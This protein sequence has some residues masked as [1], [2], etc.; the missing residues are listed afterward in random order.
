MSLSPFN[1]AVGA[2][3][4]ILLLQWLLKPK[5][6]APLP[7]G[8]TGLPIVGNVA[9][10]PA[11]KEWITFAEWGRK[12]GGILSVK[13]LGQPMIIV[14]SAQIM[15]ELDKQGSVYSDRPRLEMGGELLGYSSTLVLVPYGARFRTFRK[16]FSRHFGTPTIMERH[17]PVVDAET[18]KFL[19]RTLANP[20]NL[21]HNLRLLAG[22]IIMELTYGYEVQEKDDPFVNLI[23][24]SN[25]NFSAASVPGAFAVDFF[26]AMKNFPEWLPGMGFMQLAREWAQATKDMIEVPWNY[27]KKEM[28]AGTARPSFVT[29]IL[30]DEK[31]MS[32]EDIENVKLAASSMYGGGA[33]TTVSAEYAFFLAMVLFPEVQKKAQAEIDAVIGTDRL[34][35]MADRPHLPYVN[36]LVTEVLRWNSVAPTGKYVSIVLE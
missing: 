34:P 36:A 31:S 9:D 10:M 13:L 4:S 23:E 3:S 17:N 29:E 11:K 15:A 22:G 2:V 5:Q 32:P 30:E 35:T 28:A 19:K 20:D 18:K 25:A 12:Y 1:A 26:P 27:T 24:G 6:P 21:S 7:P 8:P 14:N 33:D 16:Y